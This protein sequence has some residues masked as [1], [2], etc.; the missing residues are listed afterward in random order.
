MENQIGCGEG[1]SGKEKAARGLSKAKGDGRHGG[2]EEEEGEELLAFL[3]A[4]VGQ[5]WREVAEKAEAEAVDEV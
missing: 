2:E 1:S 4:S 5:P 3:G